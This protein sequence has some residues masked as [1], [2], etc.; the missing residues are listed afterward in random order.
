[1]GKVVFCVSVKKMC[2][3]ADLLHSKYARDSVY[4]NSLRK[5]GN[6]QKQYL[7]LQHPVFGDLG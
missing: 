1:M 5:T 2:A 3:D 7:K 4:H 6:K